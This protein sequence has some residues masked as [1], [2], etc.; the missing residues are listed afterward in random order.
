MYVIKKYDNQNWLNCVCLDSLQAFADDIANTVEVNEILPMMMQQHL[1][2]SD[3]QQELINP[4]HT[5]ATKQ[6]KLC[7]IILGL[8]EDCVN[9]FLYC[10]L[11]TSHYE[12]HRQLYDKLYTRLNTVA[13]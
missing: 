5:T 10:L 4:M 3:Q 7:S 11:Q 13:M 12:P 1:V 8:P 2:T 9:Q 6:Q